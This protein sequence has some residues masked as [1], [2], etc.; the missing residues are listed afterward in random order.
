MEHLQ[1]IKRNKDICKKIGVAHN[2]ARISYIET[3]VWACSAFT[4]RCTK[5]SEDLLWE[6]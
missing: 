1:E 5:E 3:L 4:R 6:F 2:E